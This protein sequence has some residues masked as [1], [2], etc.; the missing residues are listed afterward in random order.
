MARTIVVPPPAMPEHAD[1]EVFTNITFN[2]DD[3]HLREFEVRFALEGDGVLPGLSADAQKWLYRPDWNMM[4]VTR[5]GPGVPAEWFSCD[6][7][8]HVFCIM[9]R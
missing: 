4:R 8:S 7:S 2:A 9:L 6:I 1:T 3:A 5:R